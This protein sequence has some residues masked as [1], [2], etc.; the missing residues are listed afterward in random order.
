MSSPRTHSTCVANPR[1]PDWLDG[2]V[3]TSPYYLVDERCGPR[4]AQRPPHFS[5]HA[6]ARMWLFLPSLHSTNICTLEGSLDR[7]SRDS[8]GPNVVQSV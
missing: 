6:T 4:E 8:H 7:G 2:V 3:S 5:L 1:P